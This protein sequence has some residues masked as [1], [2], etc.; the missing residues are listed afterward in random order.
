MS[1]NNSNDTIGIQSR[2]LPVCSAVP[3]PLRHQQRA[4]RLIMYGT[5]IKPIGDISLTLETL[6]YERFYT[7][8]MKWKMT[9]ICGWIF[10]VLT[11]LKHWENLLKLQSVRFL[12][13]WEKKEKRLKTSGKVSQIICMRCE[14][15][16][17]NRTGPHVLW[18]TGL[19][20]V[21]VLMVPRS[22]PVTLTVVAVNIEV[23]G[24]VHFVFTD[25]GFPFLRL[26]VVAASSSTWFETRMGHTQ[27]F[28]NLLKAKRNM[29]YIRNQS[30]PRCKHF[31]PRL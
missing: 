18:S 7:C 2:D 24:R 4:D 20:S 10:E 9:V 1:V 25:S 15:V 21:D 30:V 11:F 22:E 16:W 12:C 31:P 6:L 14:T 17:L 3:Q 28:I 23:V 19:R 29:L 5:N 26:D 27:C 13:L 8:F